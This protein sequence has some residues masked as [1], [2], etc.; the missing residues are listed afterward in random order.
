MSTQHHFDPNAV[1]VNHNNSADM[2]S[3]GKNQRAG[4]SGA[5]SNHN[6]TSIIATVHRLP[7]V[8]FS[9]MSKLVTNNMFALSPNTWQMSDL[10]NT[11]IEPS[12]ASSLLSDIQN[13]LTTDNLNLTDITLI[14][15]G[16]SRYP[17][18]LSQ[19]PSP[20][21]VLYVRGSV[22]AWHRTALA[23]VGTRRPTPYGLSVTTSL[24]EPVVRAGLTIVSGLALGIDGQAHRV[25]VKYHAPTVA[26]L[27][28]GIDQVYPWEHRQLADD[29]IAGGGA[30]ISEFPL[31]AE[32]ER[33]HFPQRNRIIS[34]LAKA[35]LL[36]EAGEKSGA[37]I[38]AKFA[39]EQNREVLVVP[40]NI[41]S[42]TSIGPL[43]WLKLGATPI[44]SADDILRV[45]DISLGAPPPVISSYR[46]QSADEQ[47]LLKLLA[48]GAL[49]I[50][51]LTEK[52]RLD[53]SVVSATLTLLE[54]NGAVHHLGGLVYAL[55]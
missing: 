1:L 10:I 4:Q 15:L 5:G 29:I 55:A 45:F 31:G 46:P 51:E 40:G 3:R 42:P 26:V 43:N 24:L 2:L 37:L 17:Y 13:L 44:I 32:P 30:I 18:L 27:G 16:D 54:I 8:T 19:I 7:S 33:H 41:T 53:N 38:T 36:V 48:V 35:V 12:R 28:C 11:G 9:V 21:P 20:P 47:V 23:V 22:E 14:T 6:S 34:G 49:H 25:A 50:D 52:S 39:V